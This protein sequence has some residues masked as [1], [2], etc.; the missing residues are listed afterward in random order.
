MMRS[1]HVAFIT[2]LMKVLPLATG[3]NGALP[4]WLF[5]IRLAGTAMVFAIGSAFP[6]NRRLVVSVA[7][8]AVII[9]FAVLFGDAVVLTTAVLTKVFLAKAF[10]A[11]AFL[12]KAF[13]TKAFSTKAFLATA[14][15]ATAFFAT[16]LLA[17]ALLATALRPIIVRFAT[18]P[19]CTGVLLAFAVVTA[20]TRRRLLFRLGT[21]ICRPFIVLVGRSNDAVEPLTD[22]HA[23]T[24]RGLPRSLACFRT[25]T[26]Q[27]S[28]GRS[29]SFSRPNHIVR[30]RVCP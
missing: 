30:S 21:E 23:G 2:M 16:T 17:T 10:L 27:N 22:R 26:S 19:I 5:V 29:I 8:T 3:L 20:A 7:I 25:E 13:S 28:T 12:T 18:T 24:A 14:F 11:K 6:R 1:A 4:A 9:G 15:L